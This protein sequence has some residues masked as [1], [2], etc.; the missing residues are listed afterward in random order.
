MSNMTPTYLYLYLHLYL[1]FWGRRW[2]Y[3]GFQIFDDG[4]TMDMTL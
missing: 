1:Y 2:I 3:D 4:F